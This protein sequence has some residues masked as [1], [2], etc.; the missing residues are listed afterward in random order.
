MLNRRKAEWRVE[1]GQQKHKNSMSERLT[2]ESNPIFQ[3]EFWELG[4]FRSMTPASPH[5]LQGNTIWFILKIHIL[6]I[7]DKLLFPTKKNEPTP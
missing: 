6:K 5:C 7:H 3:E 4:I 2:H 1:Y